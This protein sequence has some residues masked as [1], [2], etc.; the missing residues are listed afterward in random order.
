MRVISVKTKFFL[1][2]WAPAVVFCLGLNYL[3]LKQFKPVTKGEIKIPEE[4]RQFINTLRKLE[5]PKEIPLQALDLPASYSN[6]FYIQPPTPPDKGGNLSEA[7]VKEPL[8][9]TMIMQIDQRVCIINNKPYKEG[10]SIGKIKIKK[11]GDYYVDLE[12]SKRKIVRLEIGAT[13]TP[14]D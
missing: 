2:F 14:L 10:D 4:H 1:I 5:R 13:Y 12:T 11:I 7:K 8:K 6:P 3:F 9:L